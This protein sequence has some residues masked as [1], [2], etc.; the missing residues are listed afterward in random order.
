[1]TSIADPFQLGEGANAKNANYGLEGRFIWSVVH[2]PLDHYINVA[3][4]T[5]YST[6]N[7]DLDSNCTS[8]IDYCSLFGEPQEHPANGWVVTL[9]E[10]EKEIVYCRNF[11]VSDLV[12]CRAYDR[13]HDQLFNYTLDHYTYD[14]L[15]S[16]KL[17]ATTLLPFDCELNAYGQAC[18]ENVVF[19]THYDIVI[20]MLSSG[21]VSVNFERTDLS[22]DARWIRNVWL[23]DGDLKVVFETRVRH[24]EPTYQ[25]PHTTALV[26]AHVDPLTE[27]G[28]PLS[29]AEDMVPCDNQDGF[30]VQTWCLVSEDA[31]A[32]QI[33][34][35]SGFKKLV[36]AVKVNGETKIYVTINF[37]I[38]AY[39]YGS[40]THVQS[41]VDAGLQLYTDPYFND[42]Y[43]FG[44]GKYFIDC[45]KIYGILELSHYFQ[46][47]EVVIRRAYVCY[48][49]EHDLLPYDPA[50]PDSTGCS[51]PGGYV[52][53]KLVYSVY[54][55]DVIEA[56]YFNFEL[57]EDNS[58]EDSE[59]RFCFEAHAVTPH[60]QLLQIEY[61]AVDPSLQ[62][63]LSEQYTEL[64][65]QSISIQ[66]KRSND[67]YDNWHNH[68]TPDTDCDYE[69]SL[70]AVHC[71]RNKHYDYNLHRCVLTSYGG[72]HHYDND[73]GPGYYHYDDDDDS[74]DYLAWIIIVAILIVALLLIAYI[75]NWFGFG[76]YAKAIFTTHATATATATSV[77][78]Q[79]NHYYDDRDVIVQ[80]DGNVVGQQ[81]FTS[82][83]PR[84][85]SFNQQGNFQE[86]RRRNTT[87][88]Q[89]QQN[90]QQKQNE[91]DALFVF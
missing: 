17:Y 12:A 8:H 6:V 35:F 30:C 75:F 84:A 63:K 46:D 28:Y 1:V 45:G 11:T 23:E 14:T 42:P 18:G 48:S 10:Q 27:T 38:E 4:P 66:A 16:G 54:H 59:Q 73:D 25:E 81:Q 36:F 72:R 44:E 64:E 60:G 88:I 80:G 82:M 58:Y 9:D 50:Y 5:M 22:F 20:E 57:L 19:Q 13:P 67:D 53:K 78:Q 76:S 3:T 2:Q 39:H 21:T 29:I 7:V 70:Y 83:Q 87:V 49:N 37:Y 34:D 40:N 85:T 31:T 68:Y 79:H 65:S 71:D 43:Y 47:L 77:V 91:G 56:S 52:H 26:F 15:Y 32:N 89:Q 33:D 86:Q 69:H 24:I 61:H 90:N 62:L 74:N 55:H 51:T 41:Q